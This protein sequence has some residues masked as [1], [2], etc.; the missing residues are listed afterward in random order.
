M[1]YDEVWDLVL[2]T[3]EDMAEASSAEKDLVIKSALLPFRRNGKMT[4]NN[5]RKATER[6]RVYQNYYF[7]GTINTI[8]N[9]YFQLFETIICL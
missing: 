4:T 9:F 8:T 5:K 3:R 2:Q 6:K 1:L 7:A